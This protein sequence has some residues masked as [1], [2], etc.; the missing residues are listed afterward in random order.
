MKVTINA[1]TLFQ[2]YTGYPIAIAYTTEIPVEAVDVTYKNSQN[3]PLSSPPTALGKYP[4]SAVI[5]DTNYQGSDSSDLIISPV[6]CQ[7]IFENINV[8]FTG[9]PISATVYTIP[10]GHPVNLTYAPYDN[11][12][13]VAYPPTNVGRYLVRGIVDTTTQQNYLG[14]ASTSMF[15][16]DCP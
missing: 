15:I 10:G 6:I 2:Y 1:G 12:I 13:Y 14:Q 5:R 7:L 8:T 16:T 9:N 4:V 3:V 11:P